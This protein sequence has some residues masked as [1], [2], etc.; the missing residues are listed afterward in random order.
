MKHL[1]VSI[2]RWIN[3]DFPGWVECSF[4]DA[5]GVKHEIQ[6]K[7]PIFTSE[8]ISEKSKFPQTG[9]IR[10]E[11]TVISAAVSNSVYIVDTADI[12]GIQSVEGKTEFTVKYSEVY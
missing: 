10:C 8:H 11:V 7:A 9:A 3:S 1:R 2:D 6:D 12:D 5:F 4:I